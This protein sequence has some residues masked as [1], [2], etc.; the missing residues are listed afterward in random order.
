MDAGFSDSDQMSCHGVLLKR[1]GYG[2]RYF[3]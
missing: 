1:I 2:F 3:S